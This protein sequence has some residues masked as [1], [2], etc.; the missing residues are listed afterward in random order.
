MPN[1][2][3][4][5]HNSIS[6]TPKLFTKLANKNEVFHLQNPQL[7]LTFITF[8][9]KHFERHCPARV[10]RG[11]KGQIAAARGQARRPVCKTHPRNPLSTLTPA[12]T[13]ITYKDS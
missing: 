1:R 4:Y 12:P 3:Q 9:T 13:L 8:K 5:Q 10:D 6:V 11:C 7:I 2:K